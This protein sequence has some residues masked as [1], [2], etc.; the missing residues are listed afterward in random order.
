MSI[1][2]FNS[3]QLEKVKVKV[4]LAQVFV[5]LFIRNMKTN[6]VRITQFI[7]QKYHLT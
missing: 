3:S 1:Y 4:F 6:K 7:H 2:L 5:A